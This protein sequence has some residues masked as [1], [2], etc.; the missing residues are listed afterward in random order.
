MVCQ[1]FAVGEVKKKKYTR[2][3]IACKITYMAQ[4]FY[5][6]ISKKKKNEFFSCSNKFKIQICFRFWLVDYL[7]AYNIFLNK[8]FNPVFSKLN[9]YN[10]NY[11]FKFDRFK[12]DKHIIC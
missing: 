9:I 4:G 5:V 7:E 3:N 11:Y 6:Y 2:E 10:Y 12:F 1:T 8:Y